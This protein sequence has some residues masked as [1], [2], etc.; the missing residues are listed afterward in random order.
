MYN[1]QK[2][3]GW[4]VKAGGERGATDM[5]LIHTGV[6]ELQSAFNGLFV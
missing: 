5:S 2:D 4:W 3:N 1:D 6:I